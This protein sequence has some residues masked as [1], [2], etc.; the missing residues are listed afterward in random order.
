MDLEG[1]HAGHGKHLFLVV[2]LV[3]A[4][5]LG[6]KTVQDPLPESLRF[7]IVLTGH[8]QLHQL[9][10]GQPVHILHGNELPGVT[11]A[12]APR[13]F[14][15]DLMALGI[16]CVLVLHAGGHHKVDVLAGET[17]AQRHLNVA[18]CPEYGGAGGL[19]GH[20]A[21]RGPLDEVFPGGGQQVGGLKNEVKPYKELG[22]LRH[23]GSHAVEH[24][25]ALPFVNAVGHVGKGAFD[26]RLIG[27]LFK[28][29]HLNLL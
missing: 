5:G 13:F 8:Q 10:T 9:R 18:L 4:K 14:T 16:L 19:R 23:G 6:L 7:L 1:G 2:R 26:Q 25:G 28:H 22:Q 11:V 21:V 20:V 17:G 3:A 24:H 29:L 12:K 15:G 27:V